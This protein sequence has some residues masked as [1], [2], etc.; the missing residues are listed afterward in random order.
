[1]VFQSLPVVVND[2]PSPITPQHSPKSSYGSAGFRT[3]VHTLTLHEYRKQQRSPSPVMEPTPSRKLRRKGGASGGLRSIERL[4]PRPPTPE[5]EEKEDVFPLS[6]PFETPPRLRSSNGQGRDLSSIF[7]DYAALGGTSPSS[8]TNRGSLPNS[9]VYGRPHKTQSPPP[10]S[11]FSL[12]YLNHQPSTSS[13]DDLES[14]YRAYESPAKS[15]ASFKSIKKLPR[16]DGI[17]VVTSRGSFIPSDPN[18]SVT[19]FVHPKQRHD[20]VNTPEISSSRF[21][22]PP[23][24]LNPNAVSAAEEEALPLAALGPATITPPS[25]PPPST[26]PPVVVHHRG[27][28]FDL[29]NPHLSLNLDNI[30]TPEHESSALFHA[31]SVDSLADSMDSS[32]PSRLHSR[33][34]GSLRTAHRAIAGK[35][36]QD[37]LKHQAGASQHP[38]TNEQPIELS[39]LEPSVTRTDQP[40]SALNSSLANLADDEQDMLIY[41]S[42]TFDEVLVSSRA[43]PPSSIYSRDEFTSVRYSQMFASHAHKEETEMPSIAPLRTTRPIPLAAQSSQNNAEAKPFVQE[44]DFTPTGKGSFTDAPLSYGGEL[45]FT[46]NTISIQ[47][48]AESGIQELVIV[49]TVER[50][51]T[52]ASS[53]DTDKLLGIGSRGL[54]NMWKRDSLSRDVGI[55]LA[56]RTATGEE[57]AAES[58]PSE[59]SDWKTIDSQDSR[60]RERIS[61]IEDVDPRFQESS[62]DN[63]REY[64][65][66]VS[67]ALLPYASPYH[68]SDSIIN[69]H[70]PL[71]R[72]WDAMNTS[73]RSLSRADGASLANT[74]D[75]N[76]T[77]KLVPAV[78]SLHKHRRTMSI[79]PNFSRKGYNKTSGSSIANV[80]SNSEEEFDHSGHITEQIPYPPPMN[81]G[82]DFSPITP[83][84]AGKKRIRELNQAY[85]TPILRAPSK[86]SDYVR[87]SPSTSSP[88]S[89][90]SFGTDPYS[91]DAVYVPGPSPYSLSAKAS[92]ES[93]KSHDAPPLH[94]LRK[95]GPGPVYIDKGKYRDLRH[96]YQVAEGEAGPSRPSIAIPEPAVIKTSEE[97]QRPFTRFPVPSYYNGSQRTLVPLLRPSP[98]PRQRARCLEYPTLVTLDHRREIFANRYRY[99]IDSGTI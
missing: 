28:S 83:K 33:K 23:S 4:P 34:F 85:V 30:E 92:I 39:E 71:P 90:R 66:S 58:R 40:V 82:K 52:E 55:A 74:S 45:N 11:F 64:E 81:A 7:S 29:I 46:G 20:S 48:K 38:V 18:I 12:T 13:S 51:S 41:P 86:V 94:E 21:P 61:Y 99:N 88:V 14:L 6:R 37:A 5:E 93:W 15:V 84:S 49:P 8:L 79:V 69:S 3:P 76:S 59:S 98:L 2:I 25:T 43:R 95:T 65:T 32:S 75:Y 67:D 42:H 72:P 89:P 22:S 31:S 78:P 53:Y 96:A 91:W 27:A 10:S 70:F 63:I 54:A 73:E 44:P 26:P 50:S 56:P 35:G 24:R 16:P 17:R 9:V 77:D 62:Y 36:R 19:S 68:D 1:M 60:P 87:D 80:S 97:L 57:P 47:D